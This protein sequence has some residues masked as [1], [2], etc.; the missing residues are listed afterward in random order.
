[1]R[2]V[3]TTIVQTAA[4]WRWTVR[5]GDREASGVEPTR[6]AAMRAA[7]AAREVAR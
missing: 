6:A 1:M 7:E 4:G 5:S 2:P 3:C